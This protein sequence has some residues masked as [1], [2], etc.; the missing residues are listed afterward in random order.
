MIPKTSRKIRANS[1]KIVKTNFFH[2]AVLEAHI[3]EKVG[4]ENFFHFFQEFLRK[5]LES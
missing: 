5:F 2:E 1:G 4:F 3:V